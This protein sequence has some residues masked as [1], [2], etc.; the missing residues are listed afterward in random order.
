M[1]SPVT[2]V[3]EPAIIT[4]SQTAPLV[5]VTQPVEITAQAIAAAAAASSSRCNIPGVLTNDQA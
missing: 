3:M 4:M 1:D 5:V 2:M